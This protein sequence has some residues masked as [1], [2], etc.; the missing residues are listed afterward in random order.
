MLKLS[1]AFPTCDTL[2]IKKGIKKGEMSESARDNSV[3]LVRN[4]GGTQG[5]GLLADSMV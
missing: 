3:F 5:D 2:E 4:L 1:A